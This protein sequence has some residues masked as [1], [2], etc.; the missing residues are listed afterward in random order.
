MIGLTLL[1]AATM[2]FAAR[3]LLVRWMR[4]VMRRGGGEIGLNDLAI[5][6]VG[7]LLCA[8]ATNLIGIFAIFGAFFFGAALSSE[9][10]FCEAV[11]RR[12]R[13]FMTVFF[14]PIF[15]TFTGLRT[16]IALSALC[17]CG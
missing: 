17:K 5:L 4:W 14:V 2:I 16:D 7:I 15:F 12:M 6:I 1:F 3:P 9:R 11:L 8:C 10:E 13:D